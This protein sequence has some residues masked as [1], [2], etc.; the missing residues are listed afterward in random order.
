VVRLGNSPVFIS[1]G[2]ELSSVKNSGLRQIVKQISELLIKENMFT[3]KDVGLLDHDRNIH[4]GEMQWVFCLVRN[5]PSVNC[6]L[7]CDAVQGQKN[8][9]YDVN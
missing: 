8:K 4:V 7:T 3:E 1:Q 9:D 6:Q 5:A 2:A